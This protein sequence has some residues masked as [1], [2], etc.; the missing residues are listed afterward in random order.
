MSTLSFTDLGE[1]DRE[2]TAEEHHWLEELASTTSPA[3]FTARMGKSLAADDA[4]EP[5][6]TRDPRTGRWQAGRYIGELYRDGRVLEIRPRLGIETI[7]H[8]A[9]AALNV[10]IL[11]NTAEH[12]DSP[13][14]IAEL[15]AAT[16]RSTL[17][18]AARHGLPGLRT[19]RLHISEHAR[20]RIDVAHTL[21][22]RAAQRPQ[23]ASISRPKNIDNPISRIIVLADRV[24]DRRLKRRD[25]R[26][27]RIEEIM[28][29]LRAAVGHR[30][31]LP[32]PRELASVR[33]T[34]ITLPYRRVAELS[35]QIARHRGLRS[36]ATG[37]STEGLL[38]DVAELWELFLVHCAKRAFGTQ[39]VTHGTH[40]RQ[41]RPLLCSQQH[42]TATLGRLYPDLLIGPVDRPTAIID[43]KYKRLTNRYGVD[44]ADLYQLNAY[45]AA[46][47]SAPLPSGTLAYVRFPDK[48]H[49][50]PRLA[51]AER[52]GPWR[53]MHGHTVSFERF[54]ITEEECVAALQALVL[55][56]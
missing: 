28:P 5:I 17:A 13:A 24:L 11:P 8:W 25:W 42:E 49:Y 20:G 55:K 26:G 31:A 46:H 23:V 40:L 38:I 2:P 7:A 35:Y 39:N 29:R 18:D 6:V 9:G 1:A 10:Q 30:P 56:R 22:L 14:L 19:P 4:D 27:E 15:V 48:P 52:R 51:D 33:Y 54:P 43:A 53:T 36:Q 21:R 44:R 50:E 45:L 3:A 34:P 16:W 37:E 41:G 47:T 32:T 12:T